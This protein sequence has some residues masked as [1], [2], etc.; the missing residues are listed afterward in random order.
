MRSLLVFFSGFFRRFRIAPPGFR[1]S[2]LGF[3]RCKYSMIYLKAP[4]QC[5]A[6]LAEPAGHA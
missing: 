3:S 5:P 6:R 2:G 4:F 1:A